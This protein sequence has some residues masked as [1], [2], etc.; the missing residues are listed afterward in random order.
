MNT[1]LLTILFAVFTLVSMGVVVAA[2]SNAT[3]DLEVLS[4]DIN[5]HEQGLF[6]NDLNLEVARG[7]KLDLELELG[8]L[9]DV[10]DVQV[11]AMIGGYEYSNYEFDKVFDMSRTFNLQA[12]D[13]KFVSLELEVPVNID[14]DY[15]KLYIEVHSR[16]ELRQSYYYELNI[17]NVENGNEVLIKDAYLSPSS[18]V[19]AG[20]ALTA[21]VRVENIGQQDFDDATL[22][23]KVPALNIQ[24]V[25]T[26]ENLEVGEKETFEELVLRFPKDAQ[27]GDYVVEYTVK[28]DEYESVTKTAVVHVSECADVTCGAAVKEN[29]V[30]TQLFFDSEKIVDAKSGA[31]FPIMIQNT[32]NSQKSYTLAVSGVDSWGTATLSEG[33]LVVVPAGAMVPVYVHVVAND[34]AAAGEHSFSV[35]VASDGAQDVLP[36]KAV[37]TEDGSKDRSGLQKALEIGLIVLVV[38]LIL[39]GLIIGFNKLR[40]SDDDED[41]K[42]Y[43]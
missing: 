41:A 25:E 24:A 5:G 37:V 11:S 15:A 35:T 10:S 19:M 1:K 26:I 34:N 29:D 42:T 32:G 40:G 30:V 3:V 21:T 33:S 39:I 31:T 38:I 8:T 18:E 22:L 4:L 28:Y 9:A 12:G 20:R 13:K 27:P 17:V 14:P 7:E 43:Y 23:V 2:P 36:M 6:G 16:D